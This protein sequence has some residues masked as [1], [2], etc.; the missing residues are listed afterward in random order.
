MSRWWEFGNLKYGDRVKVTDGFH[1]GKEGMVIDESHLAHN[2]RVKFDS[3]D[4]GNY[5]GDWQVEK[6]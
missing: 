3:E 4:Y 6:I 5:I 1:K 2:Y